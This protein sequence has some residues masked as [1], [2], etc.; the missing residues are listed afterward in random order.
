MLCLGEGAKA[1][2]LSTKQPSKLP[3]LSLSL[4]LSLNPTPETIN[5]TRICHAGGQRR[6]RQRSKVSKR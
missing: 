3:N 5:P 4:A 1:G 6:L 2:I